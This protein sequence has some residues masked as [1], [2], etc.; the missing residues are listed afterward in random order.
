MK[1]LSF[2]FENK[3]TKQTIF[4]N[5]FWV[6]FSAG[7]CK[8]IRALIIIYIARVLGPLDY[9]KFSFALAFV[10]LFVSFFDMGISTMV[11]REFT[12]D[13][14]K[15]EFNSLI[16]LRIFLG[17][18][19][20]A[21]IFFL[22]FFAVQSQQI[23]LLIWIMALASFL[24]QFPEIFYSFFRSREKMEYE[25]FFNILQV[26]LLCFFV[27]TATLSFLS[28]ERVSYVYF[29]ANFVILIPVIIFFN[30][31][32]FPIK[33][34]INFSVWKKF[35][36]I[37]LPLALTSVFSMIYSYIDST[38]LGSS[39]LVFE[40]GLYNAA[41][42]IINIV[43]LPAGII[44][45][46][47]YPV[48]SKRFLDKERFQKAFDYQLKI[49]IL[50]VLPIVVAG[51]LG[52]EK[53]INFIYGPL[54]KSAYPVF[55]I[56]ILASC[57]SYLFSIFSQTLIAA[58]QQWKTFW[59]AFAGALINT[60]MNLILIPKLSFYGAAIANF[61][62]YGAM[63]VLCLFFIYKNTDINPFNIFKKTNEIF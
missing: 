40:T 14:N 5:A 36:I 3:T 42:K 1:A 53:I 51:F 4:K 23:R 13:N 49:T 9:G 63:L 59:V 19:T 2:L 15:E 37:S 57:M 52:A 30:Y 61:I 10:S 44:S 7:I 46:V 24:G 35:L 45:M 27:F 33:F 41:L 20:V 11:T 26:V 16:F 48:L 34:I 56:L 28:P 18:L 22:S 31:K 8:A 55:Q 58:N 32:V 43:V 25:S 21:L 38:I 47:F 17:A 39:N 60:A 12:K 29:L 54:Y 50:T 6:S 62:T